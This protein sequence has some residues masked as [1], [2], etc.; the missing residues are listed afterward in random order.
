[1]PTELFE[2]LVTHGYIGETWH[3]AWDPRLAEVGLRADFWQRLRV[4]GNAYILD[5]AREHELLAEARTADAAGRALIESKIAGMSATLCRERADALVAARR[6][7]GP[8]VDRFLYRVVAS[9]T[10]MYFEEQHDPIRLKAQ[11]DGCR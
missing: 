5:L 7:L 3:D 8:A 6:E 2:L 9:G 4:I 10:A 1:M 11:E